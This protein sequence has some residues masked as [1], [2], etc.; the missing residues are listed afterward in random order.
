M[1]DWEHLKQREACVTLSRNRETFP[2]RFFI[3]LSVTRIS[4]LFFIWCWLQKNLAQPHS[5]HSS[6]SLCYL[7][8]PLLLLHIST[9]YVSFSFL[10]TLL[11]GTPTPSPPLCAVTLATGTLKIGLSSFTPDISGAQSYCFYW[12]HAFSYT[13]NWP[14]CMYKVHHFA[15]GPALSHQTSTQLRQPHLCSTAISF[16]MLF[17]FP[18]SAFLGMH[19]MATNLWV[20]LS[21][22]RTT[23]EKAPLKKTRTHT[24]T[25]KKRRE[26]CRSVGWNGQRRIYSSKAAGWMDLKDK[27]DATKNTLI[28]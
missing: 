26:M 21:S 20:P 8:T 1:S 23:S 10:N 15:C 2:I 12:H 13:V 16:S 7:R 6:I 14:P 18:S 5:S 11:R 28:F 9:L 19:L 4:L 24:H 27:K 25:S 17:S 22:A 3:L